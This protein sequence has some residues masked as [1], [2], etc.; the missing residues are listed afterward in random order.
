[1]ACLSPL[2]TQMDKIS[3]IFQKNKFHMEVNRIM[4]IQHKAVGENTNKYYKTTKNMFHTI[5]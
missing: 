4:E 5:D 1:M 2:D 3:N